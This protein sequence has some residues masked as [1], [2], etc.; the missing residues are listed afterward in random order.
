MKMHF[1]KP[2]TAQKNDAFV[3]IEEIP[4]QEGENVTQQHQNAPATPGQR[5]AKAMRRFAYRLFP[6]IGEPPLDH[7]DDL[8]KR[9]SVSTSKISDGEVD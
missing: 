6:M 8:H 9:A 1:T 2:G 5:V 3:V 4:P 7:L